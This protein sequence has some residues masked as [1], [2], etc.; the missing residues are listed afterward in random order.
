MPHSYTEDELVE[1]PAI[2][3]FTEL[4]WQT[5]SARDEIF[6]AGGTLRRETKSEVVLMGRLKAALQR[7]NP[8]LP[9]EAITLAL[10]ELTRDRSTKAPLAAN[11]EVYDRLKDG[12][13]VSIPDRKHSGQTTERLRVIDWQN[14][15]ANDFLL[16]N[17]FSV[18]KTP[19]TCRPDLIGFVNGLP[20]IVIELKKPG[21]PAQVAF[22]DNLTWYKGVIPQLFWSNPVLITSNGFDSRVGS[23]TSNWERFFE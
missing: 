18:T 5:M 22:E 14:P 6:G 4:G 17:Q 3:L 16:T 12:V 20:I 15:D 21:V 7:F 8:Q 9:P 1:Q 11:R 13:I 23:L 10:N 19:Y 2:E